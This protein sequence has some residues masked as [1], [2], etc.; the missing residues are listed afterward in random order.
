MADETGPPDE[1]LVELADQMFDLARTG[2]ADRLLAYVEAGVR[3]PSPT[4]PAT[5]C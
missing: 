4:R 1:R 2:E 3:V 5:P